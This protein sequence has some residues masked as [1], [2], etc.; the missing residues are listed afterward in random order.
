[1]TSCVAATSWATTPT[2]LI[3]AS[4]PASAYIRELYDLYGNPGF[5][6]AYN[7]GPGRLDD[8]L[9]RNRALPEETRRYVAKIGPYITDSMPSR[10]STAEVY[11]LNSLP[12]TIPSGPRYSSPADAP[13]SAPKAVEPPPVEVAFAPADVEERPI[14]SRPVYPS[15][16]LAA[17][18]PPATQVASSS[19]MPSRLEAAPVPAHEPDLM[20]VTRPPVAYDPPPARLASPSLPP[21]VP[22]QH[23]AQIAALPEPPRYTPPVPTVQTAAAY[24]YA[25]QAP[26]THRDTGFRFVSPATGR[27]CPHLSRSTWR[28]GHPDRRVRQRGLGA[29]SRRCRT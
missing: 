6:A 14:S 12:T 2:T 1:M 25:A 11:A 17:S 18:T 29:A 5:L 9:T 15:P 16:V 26:A 7:G 20:P 10:R 22:M 23:P 3:T 28:V 13:Y 4:L 19:A 8:Y 27:T 24:G 21:R